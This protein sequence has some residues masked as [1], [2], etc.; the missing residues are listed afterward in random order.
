MV[1]YVNGRPAVSPPTLWDRL[2]SSGPVVVAVVIVALVAG[3]RLLAVPR[4]HAWDLPRGAIHRKFIESHHDFVST[5]A[6]RERTKV[7]HIG[8]EAI[9]EGHETLSD[10]LEGDW[11]STLGGITRCSTTAA[12]VAICKC[13]ILMRS[14]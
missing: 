12:A 13:A 7:E 9:T 3:P 10:M 5:Y 2:R 8:L 14:S 11:S 6:P 1:L 4:P